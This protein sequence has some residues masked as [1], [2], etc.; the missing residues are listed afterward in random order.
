MAEIKYTIPDDKI[1]EFKECFLL[2]E[3]KPISPV[4]EVISDNAWI[5]KWGRMKF[6]QAYHKGKKLKVAQSIQID[7]DMIV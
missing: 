1:D 2:A 3:P 6:M 7:E 5:K 4:G